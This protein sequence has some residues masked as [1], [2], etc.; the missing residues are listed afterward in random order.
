MEWCRRQAAAPPQHVLPAPEV[1]HRQRSRGGSVSAAASRRRRRG[2][3]GRRRRRRAAEEAVAWPGWSRTQRR[4][5]Q[6]TARVAVIR[7]LSLV[8]EDSSTPVARSCMTPM[9]RQPVTPNWL[10]PNMEGA[11]C[12]EK[13]SLEGATA[14]ASAGSTTSTTVLTRRTIMTTTWGVC[15]SL[16]TETLSASFS[17]DGAMSW[18]STRLCPT[19]L[20]CGR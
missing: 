3:S 5:R 10:S 12:R 6:R 13:P 11:S 19:R 14:L 8:D 4:R 17:A 1:V 16:V 7:R 9:A 20:S 18:W 15:W 2:D